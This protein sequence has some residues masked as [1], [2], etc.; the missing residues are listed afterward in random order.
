MQHCVNASRR[1]DERMESRFDIIIAGAGMVGVTLALGLARRG[2]AI[3]VIDRE[4]LSTRLD[5][6]FDGR[7]TAVS[8][9]AH[10]LLKRLDAWEGI[11]PY[12]EPILDIRVSDANSPFFLDYHYREVGTHPFGWIVENRCIRKA[13]A[14]AAAEYDNIIPIT[15]AEP[16]A[17]HRTD[18]AAEITL[19]DG[20][21]LRAGLVV[22]AD[23]R[24]S[25]IRDMAGIGTFSADYKQTAIVCTIAHEQPH[26]GLAQERFLPAGP[27]AVLPMQEDKNT[28]FW[29]SSLVW[30]ER[31]A[32]APLL[33]RLPEAE[34]IQEIRERTGDYLGEIRTTGPR[35]SYP[36]Q[37]MHAKR[38]A[39]PRVAL[40]GDAAHGIHPI[41]GQGVNLGW[42]DVAVLTELVGEHARLGLD[43]GDM[44][45]L[46]HYER[47][48]RADN[49]TM[50]AVTDGLN[51][52]FSNHLPPLKLARGLGL[53]AVGQLP[54][55]KKLFM[56]DAMG[57][58]GDLP[59]LMQEDY[60][61]SA[62]PR[63]A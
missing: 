41:A 50:L 3:A 28:K 43:I 51:R 11:A 15:P 56:R 27:F 5:P 17:L 32:D 53:W 44:A 61:A 49:L 14:D 6:T 19:M 10:R 31:S 46:R 60:P 7:T 62:P 42:R 18:H 29:R 33:M 35:F 16:F 52:L 45:M 54:P 22:G 20:R 48:R 40:A 30:T 37:V 8:F 57:L 9:G 58:T 39:S 4:P 21:V 34:F 55:L 59:A 63:A 12:A 13:L 36:L 47:W 25:R 26:H 2:L 24:R 38:Y 23:G 1:Y